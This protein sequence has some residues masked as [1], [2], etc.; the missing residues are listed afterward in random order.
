M[1]E[2]ILLTSE[3]TEIGPCHNDAD[4]DIGSG[5]MASNDFE[6]NGDLP[7]D[8]GAIYVPGTEFGGIFEYL[9]E[10]NYSPVRKRKGWTWRGL[11]TQAIILPPSGSDYRVVS[12][13]ANAVMRTLLSGVLGDFFYVPEI[14]S[15]IVIN[16]YQFKLYCTVLEGLTAMLESAGAKLRI[17]AEKVAAGQPIRVT[18]EAA[19]AVTLGT[20]Y[21]EESPVSMTYV[22][23]GMGINHLICMGKGELQDR[24]KVDLYVNASGNVVS[25][26]YFT[27]LQERQAYF[28][29]P[30]AQSR[31]DLIASGKKKL[32]ELRSS[33][34]LKVDDIDLE[35]DVG[36]KVYGYMNGRGITSPI[37]RKTLTIKGD[38]WTCETGVE[39]EH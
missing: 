8:A 5:D 16:S 13:E 9:Q 26:K 15:G 1:D 27:G 35:G 20:V 17:H 12:G 36:D 22:E 31:D 19:A 18:V 6:I 32:L 21:S 10:T 37:T 3:L 28:D 2:L 11:L 34:S 4:F 23:N 14:D 33:S 24:M 25:T 38:T 7:D 30:S 29:Y 39:G